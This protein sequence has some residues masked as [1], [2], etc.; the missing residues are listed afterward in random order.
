MLWVVVIH[1]VHVMS[2]VLTFLLC[3]RPKL[4]SFAMQILGGFFPIVGADWHIVKD[5][6][7][8]ALIMQTAQCSTGMLRVVVYTIG[9]GH[10]LWLYGHI[11]LYVRKTPVEQSLLRSH[12]LAV[13]MV[14]ESPSAS[15]NNS[16]DTLKDTLL[17]QRLKNTLRAQFVGQLAG[18][19][20]KDKEIQAYIAEL[21]M[22]IFGL[23]QVYFSQLSIFMVASIGVATVK[24]TSAPF[25][26]TRL[27]PS[28]V[29]H[30][31]RIPL[32]TWWHSTLAD[33]DWGKCLT[34]PLH[35][36]AFYGGPSARVM[37]QLAK[38]S[39]ILEQALL[40]KD[41]FQRTPLHCVAFEDS[42]SIAQAIMDFAKEH[43][44]DLLEQVLLAKDESQD[45]PLPWA[46]FN[47]GPTV[48][49]TLHFAKQHSESLLEQ[50]LLA[51]ND[52]RYTPLHV[53]VEM[54]RRTDTVTTVQH[55]MGYAKQHS[56]HLL[57]QA[58]LAEDASQAT[59]LH[60]AAYCDCSYS[61]WAIMDFAKTHSDN[62]LEQALMAR[63]RKQYTPLHVAV[64]KG[65]H[66]TALAIMESAKQHSDRFLEQVL[67]ARTDNQVTPFHGAAHKGRIDIAL[68]VMESA[69]QHSDRLL[70]QVLL[71]EDGRQNTPLGV[72]AHEPVK[73]A[74][75]EC[76]QKMKE[77]MASRPSRVGR[78]AQPATG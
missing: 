67:L 48:Q 52:K 46:A 22:A 73:Q 10:F 32:Q 56:D 70:E 62:L 36:A 29:A 43:S 8:L 58:L 51:R 55:I 77:R 19:C 69:E 9:Y 6:M 20:S 30:L 24:A 75:K 12:L 47:E 42:K 11:A 26:R 54:G 71:A 33:M 15:A 17:A 68:A 31:S 25:L 60:R 61:A 53:A 74:I 18:A 78:D 57:E 34:T 65:A 7:C 41:E 1:S 63:T 44:D 3:G 64:G 27:V 14:L 50:A 39:D 40:A 49:A 2:T 59:P 35:G 21:P 38:D 37:L 76:E 13:A 66:D 23:L 72:A 16:Q 45:T 5:H 4:Q 28:W